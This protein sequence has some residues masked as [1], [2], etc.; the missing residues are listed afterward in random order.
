MGK[1]MGILQALLYLKEVAE[2]EHEYDIA[3]NLQRVAELVF[4]RAFHGQ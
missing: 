4:L 3:E 2:E 1:L